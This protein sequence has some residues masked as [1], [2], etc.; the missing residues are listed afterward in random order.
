MVDL[1]ILSSQD[2]NWW[3]GVVWIIVMFLS[4]VW[5]LIL[6]APIHIHC[7]DSDA[8]L[9]FSKSDE[10]TNS[11]TSWM[12]WGWVHFNFWMKY[13]FNPHRYWRKKTPINN[14]EW[15]ALTFFNLKMCRLPF[16]LVETFFSE[17]GALYLVLRNR[18]ERLWLSC[19][20]Y[21]IKRVNKIRVT[22]F[23]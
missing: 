8:M 3:T 9:H 19:L 12:A 4:A 13:S 10:E 17:A 5:T 20:D 7:W 1:V 21:K 2:V 6:T 11:S 14:P 22:G 15:K 18:A 16:P 23:V